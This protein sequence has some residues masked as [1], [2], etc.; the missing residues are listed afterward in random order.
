MYAGRTGDDG[1]R[2]IEGPLIA[3]LGGSRPDAPTKGG[4]NTVSRKR[5]YGTKIDPGFQCSQGLAACRA[6]VAV[7]AQKNPPHAGRSGWRQYSKLHWR[8]MPQDTCAN[9]PVNA[10]DP[11]VEPLPAAI[12][13]GEDEFIVSNIAGGG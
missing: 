7:E 9:E 13:K 4:V 3:L 12:R 6:G 5:L 8:T 2:R 11:Q 1:N 10:T